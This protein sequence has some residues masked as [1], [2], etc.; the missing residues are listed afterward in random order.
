MTNLDILQEEKKSPLP[1]EIDTQALERNIRVLKRLGLEILNQNQVLAQDQ[2][3]QKAVNQLMQISTLEKL[4]VIAKELAQEIEDQPL[5]QNLEPALEK[6][7]M[8]AKD[9]TIEKLSQN[10]EIEKLQKKIKKG[11]AKKEVSSE[12]ILKAPKPPKL[13]VV[14]VKLPKDIKDDQQLLLAF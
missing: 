6:I 3:L 10:E 14:K 7:L 5:Q 1:G 13:T 4:M 9:L 8:I 2:D 12:K 11:P